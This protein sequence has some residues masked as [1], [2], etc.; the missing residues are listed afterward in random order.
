MVAAGPGLRTWGPFP[1][2]VTEALFTV[3]LANAF[4]WY[5]DVP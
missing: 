2:Q 5:E 1:D 4:T 3:S